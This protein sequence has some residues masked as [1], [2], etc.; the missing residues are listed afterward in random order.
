MF[1]EQIGDDEQ[2][3]EELYKNCNL[4]W[5]RTI[6]NV[7]RTQKHTVL[8]PFAFE[9]EVEKYKQIALEKAISQQEN[10][11]DQNEIHPDRASGTQQGAD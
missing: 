10:G 3:N 4:A 9:K 7:N 5:K 11:H 1:Y 6:N 2:K 8:D